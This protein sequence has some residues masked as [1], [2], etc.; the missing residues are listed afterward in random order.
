MDFHRELPTGNTLSSLAQAQ[1]GKKARKFQLSFVV[2]VT[3]LYE[4]R[5]PLTMQMIFKNPLLQDSHVIINLY[6]N[7]HN[8]FKAEAP[9]FPVST[10]GFQCSISQEYLLTELLYIH[11]LNYARINGLFIFRKRPHLESTQLGGICMSL[12]PHA[13]NLLC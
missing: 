5:T 2:Q 11:S 9:H 13:T 7:I 4:H 3:S 6:L 8:I 1:G 12:L 10:T